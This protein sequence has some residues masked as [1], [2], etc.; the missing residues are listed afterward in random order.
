MCRC[1]PC[2]S[3]WYTSACPASPRSSRSNSSPTTTAMTSS[4]STACGRSRA[5][6]TRVRRRSSCLALIWAASATPSKSRTAALMLYSRSI[7]AG[8]RYARMLHTYLYYM[9]HAGSVAWCAL[10]SI[11]DFRTVYC[12]LVY[13]ICFPTYCLFFTFSFVVSSLTCLFFWEFTCSVSRPDV[14]K[15][16]KPGISFLC[17]FCEGP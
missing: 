5:A 12:L 1:M 11:F 16:T 10:D 17:L 15:A 2:E 4:T 6:A 13:I 14:V 3:W 8:W 9:P 7:L